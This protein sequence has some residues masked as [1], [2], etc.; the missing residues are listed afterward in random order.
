MQIRTKLIL[1]GASSF[2]A[3]LVIGALALSST[4]LLSAN[5]EAFVEI[6]IPSR[7]YMDQVK[8]HKDEIQE[9]IAETIVD[10]VDYSEAARQNFREQLK[11]YAKTWAAVVDDRKHFAE[12]TARRPP[13]SLAVLTPIRERFGNNWKAWEDDVAPARGIIGQLAELPVG[14]VENQKK[15][16]AEIIALFEKQKA[17]FDALDASF[18]EIAQFHSDREKKVSGESEALISRTTTLQIAAGL[19]GIALVCGLSWVTFR[20]IMVPLSHTRDS[21]DAIARDNDLTRRVHVKSQDEIGALVSSFN[22]LTTRLQET[23]SSIQGKV[24]SVVSTSES[25]SS[26]AVQV[27]TSSSQQSS[28]TSAMAAAVE[29]MT[30]SITTISDSANDAQNMTQEANGAAA[31]GGEI[32][33]RTTK[34]M[35]E[36]AESVSEASQVIKMLGDE[37]Q[38]ISSVVQVIKEVADQTNLLALNA[39]IEAARAGEAGRGFA[40]V[41]DEVR[42]LA[43]RTAQSTGDISSMIGKIQVSSNEAV[44]KMQRV[45][46]QVEV[47]K[48]LAEQAGQC[49][50]AIQEGAEKVSRAV[51]EISSAMKEQNNASQDIAKHVENIAQMTDENNSAAEETSDNAQNLDKL[52]QDVSKEIMLFKL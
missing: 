52:A 7:V 26:A 24:K 12:V 2:A 8:M 41:A 14:D 1:L 39:A 5:I 45:V 33:R 42:K 29:E 38:Q 32:I 27:A 4:S 46:E 43:E 51:T 50:T 36:I 13:E 15:L 25:L 40:V 11:R 49:V 16:M 19:L 28:A 6:M 22:G 10:E 18:E 47:G 34:E 31:R 3:I 44:A 37:S 21:M 35:E 9:I 20:A 48:D 17:N 23:L 30:T